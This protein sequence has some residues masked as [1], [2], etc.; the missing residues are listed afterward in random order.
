VKKYGSTQIE[1]R[2]LEAAQAI[3]ELLSKN[4]N[5]SFIPSNS[6]G[7]LLNLKV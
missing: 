5:I 3:A 2:K 6:N 1:I 4:T 7:N